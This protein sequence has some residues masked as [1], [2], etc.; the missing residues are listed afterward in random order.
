[1]MRI[2]IE[3]FAILREQAGKEHEFVET[4]AMTPAQLFAQLSTQYGFALNNASL[5]VAVNDQFC[6]WSDSLAEG[7][8]VVFIPP[9]AGG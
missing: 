3:Y 9:V 7:D 8:R 6:D 1:M 4:T 5:R 2:E